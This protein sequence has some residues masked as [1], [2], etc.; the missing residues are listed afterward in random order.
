[1]KNGIRDLI[2]SLM[3]TLLGT[4]SESLLCLVSPS[5]NANSA[6]PGF[7]AYIFFAAEGDKKRKKLEEEK[8]NKQTNKQTNKPK[9]TNQKSRRKVAAKTL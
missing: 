6:R 3:V 5:E 9:P 1:V 7:Q 8:Y 2:S 4:H